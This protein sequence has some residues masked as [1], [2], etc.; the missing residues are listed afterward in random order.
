LIERRQE[1]KTIYNSK[2]TM[3]VVMMA[4]KESSFFSRVAQ[5]Q[6]VFRFVVM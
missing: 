3:M 1:A 6:A 5:T 4:L 2:K